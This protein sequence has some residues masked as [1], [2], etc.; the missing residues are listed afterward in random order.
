MMNLTFSRIVASA[1]LA[2]AALFAMPAGMQAQTGLVTI[3]PKSLT[4]TFKKIT[5]QTL[6]MEIVLNGKLKGK[7]VKNQKINFDI[8]EDRGTQSRSVIFGGSGLNVMLNDPSF[9]ALGVKSMAVY[10]LGKDSYINLTGK[11]SI[12][13]KPRAGAADFDKIVSQVSADKLLKNAKLDGSSFRARFVRAEKVGGEPAKKYEVETLLTV[14]DPAGS[15]QFIWIADNG[16]YIIKFDTPVPASESGGL[17]AG[18]EG[19]Q[20][21]VY[22]ISGINKPVKFVLPAACKKAIAG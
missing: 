7:T 22:T 1:G 2:A 11:Q 3:R 17:T 16:E 13:I 6:N 9:A 18:F 19:D 21:V 5:T 14:K 10:Q 4:Q 15:K 12:C 20:R 8:V